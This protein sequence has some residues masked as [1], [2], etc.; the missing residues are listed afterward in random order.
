MGTPGREPAS[1]YEH[2]QLAESFWSDFVRDHWEKTPTVIPRPF[3]KDMLDHAEALDLLRRAFGPEA[4]DRQGGGLFIDGQIQADVPTEFLPEVGEASI[5]EFANRLHTTLGLRNYQFTLYGAQR[6][7]PEVWFRTRAAFG[8]LFDLA[9]MPAFRFDTDLFFGDYLVTAAGLHKDNAAVF[10]Y[11][12]HGA[13]K[14]LVWPFEYFA[15]EARTPDAAT[16]KAALDH[17]DYTQHLDAATELQGRPGDVLYW[18]ST[19]WHVAIGDGHPHLTFNMSYYLPVRSSRWAEQVIGPL[20]LQALGE[21]DWISTFPYQRAD[22]QRQAQQ[23]PARLETTLATL[24]SAL[25]SPRLRSR[26]MVAWLT[27]LTGFGFSTLPRPDLDAVLSEGDRYAGDPD[28]PAVH[29]A[30]SD[31]QALVA[32]NGF[33]FLARRGPALDHVLAVTNAGTLFSLESVLARIAEDPAASGLDPAASREQ[34]MSYLQKLLAARAIRPEG[35]SSSK[36]Y[37]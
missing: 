18:P 12:V 23:L 15:A 3:G 34:V 37:S 26:L 27:T 28:H 4:S 8:P 35:Y 20:L 22:L 6:H 14:M 2:W 7:D 16:N 5:G 9:G 30:L 32:A 29:V 33:P 36:K 25:A 31:A 24:Q 17:V 19:W 1:P 11:V 21:D 13:K 10:S